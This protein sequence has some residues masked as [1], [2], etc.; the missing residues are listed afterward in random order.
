VLTTPSFQGVHLTLVQPV[1][2]APTFGRDALIGLGLPLLLLAL[3]QYAT[4]ITILRNAGYQV[5]AQAVVG[6]SGLVSIPLALFGSSGVNPAAIVGAICASPEC[7]PDPQRRYIAGLVC[8]LGYLCVGIFGASV[9]ALFSLLPGGLIATL[10]GLAL[11]GTL[12]SALASSMADER[13]R[14]PAL[15]T[16]VVTVSGMSFFGLGSALWGLL[17]GLL[18]TGVVS[19]RGSPNPTR[20]ATGSAAR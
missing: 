6:G 1:L 8:G 13:H 18:F 16:F 12:V 7:H 4:G 2:T 9:V 5:S 20:Q 15:I 10:A 3:T 19:W 17:A 11:L 14:E